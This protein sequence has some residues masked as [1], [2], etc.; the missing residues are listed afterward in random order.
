MSL[1]CSFFYP[2]K[3]FFYGAGAFFL[4][5]AAVLAF[6]ASFKRKAA[7]LL[8]GIM[9]LYGFNTLRISGLYYVAAYHFD[10]FTLFHTYLAPTLMIIVTCLF[11][12]WW[13][14]GSTLTN[15]DP[16]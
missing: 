2:I 3:L 4:L 9:L 12:V 11:F 16:R 7:G 8:A 13:A 5:A 10:W 6:P 14:L 1:P 15:H